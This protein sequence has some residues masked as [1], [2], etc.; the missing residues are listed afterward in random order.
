VLRR[1]KFA[2]G[3]F[4]IFLLSPVAFLILHS[5]IPF[6]RTFTYYGFVL[7]F[8][9][10][11]GFAEQLKKIPIVPLIIALIAIQLGLLY[12]FNK[13]IIT[14][15]ERDPQLNWSSKKFT[16][17]MVGNKRYFSSGNLLGTTLLYELKARGFNKAEVIFRDGPVNADSLQNFD[18][19]IIGHQ[20]DHTKVKK[21]K[22]TTAHYNIY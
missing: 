7:P 12:Q 3:L 22:V 14:Y 8:L 5:V 6:P 13:E 21:P 15:E 1:Q 9:A 16:N 10:I 17:M 18:Y 4:L 20:Y 11:A 2:I 19:I